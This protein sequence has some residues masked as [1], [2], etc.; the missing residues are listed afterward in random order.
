MA[1]A[2]PLAAVLMDQELAALEAAGGARRINVLIAMAYKVAGRTGVAVCFG[3]TGCVC[4]VLCYQA[5]RRSRTAKARG[6]GSGTS[7]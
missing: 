1:L 7:T 2:S 5:F 4:A 6:S 3:V